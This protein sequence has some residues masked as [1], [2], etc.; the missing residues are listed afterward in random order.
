MGYSA[1]GEDCKTGFLFSRRRSQ[2]CVLS[3]QPLSFLFSSQMAED[4]QI[5]PGAVGGDLWQHLLCG[6]HCHSCAAGD[7]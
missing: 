6:S 3:L 7:W 1:T 4:F 2:G 5:P